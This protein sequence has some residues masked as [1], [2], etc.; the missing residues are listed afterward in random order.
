MTNKKFDVNS[1][2]SHLY[3]KLKTHFVLNLPPPDT[4]PKKAHD[5]RRH[6]RQLNCRHTRFRPVATK[7]WTK[8]TLSQELKLAAEEST[9]DEPPQVS[10][11]PVSMEYVQC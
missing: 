1:I 4:L 9:E 6:G 2:N 3:Y 11:N 8:G 5:H 7:W 10:M